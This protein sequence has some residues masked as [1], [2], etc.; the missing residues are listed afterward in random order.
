ML[1]RQPILLNCFSRGGSNIL[2]NIL[3]SHPEVCSPIE[4]TLQIFRL[5]WRAPRSAGLKAAWLTGQL[6]Y[7]DQWLLAPRKT[8]SGRAAGFIDRTLYSWKLKTLA[9]KEMRWKSPEA[10][11]SPAEVADARL[12]LKNNNGLA[13]LT[14]E[15]FRMYPDACAL[16]LVRD[17]VPLYESHRR[18]RTPVSTTP[19]S[20]SDFYGAMVSGMETDAH[21]F[22]RYHILRFEDILSSPAEGIQR[23]YSLAG[24]DAGRVGK[25]RFKAKPYTRADGR[26]GTDLEA[27]RHYWLDLE[28]VQRMF[29][30]EVNRYQASRLDVRER[31]QIAALTEGLRT[32]LGYA[33]R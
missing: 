22:E 14:E 8:I 15:F 26:H 4:E 23:I 6:R 25:M 11:Y 12:V 27:G 2:W 24:L 1:N 19:A 28:E 32:R 7:F 9:D 5:D 10:L 17:P 33:S 20:F 18:Y 29:E 30:P 3:L 16:A 21:R 31:E 13:F